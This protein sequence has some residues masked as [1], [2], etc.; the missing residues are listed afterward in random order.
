MD[1]VRKYK[2][3]VIIMRDNILKINIME[4]VRW[5]GLIIHNMKEIFKMALFMEKEH[6]HILTTMNTIQENFRK[7][8]NMV[9]VNNNGMMDQN[10][11]VNIKMI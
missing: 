3:M 1:L 9:M 5:Y 6:L 4:K 7:I 2:L 10:M 11:L 8:K